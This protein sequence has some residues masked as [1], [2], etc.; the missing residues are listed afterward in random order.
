MSR[1]GRKR[2]GGKRY[3]SGGLV[4]VVKAEDVLRMRTSRQ[5]HRRTLKSDD[6]LD[7]RAESPLGRLLIKGVI[8]AECYDAGERYVAIVGQYRAVINTPRA[9]AGSGRGM[10]CAVD[11]VETEEMVDRFK[12]VRVKPRSCF[13]NAEDCACLRRQERYDAAYAAV[14]GVPAHGYSRA[15]M[16]GIMLGD[17]PAQLLAAVA[18]AEAARGYEALPPQDQ[19]AA[20]AVARVA[21]NGEE[22][23]REELVHLVRGLRAL[24]RHFGLT[25]KRAMAHSENAN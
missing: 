19:K 12:A 16:T 8:D 3:P 22:P 4:P 15:L 7:E 17:A 2:K 10:T 6:R 20:R 23:T 14:L 25:G 18:R 21:I 13:E 9:T 24:A 11:S 5:P 1:A